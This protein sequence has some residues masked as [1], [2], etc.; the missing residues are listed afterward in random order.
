LL[1]PD[2]NPEAEDR[3]RRLYGVNPPLPPPVEDVVFRDLSLTARGIVEPS[4]V[5][6]VATDGIDASLPEVTTLTGPSSVPDRWVFAATTCR[7]RAL[8]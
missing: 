6:K 5:L 1:A 8:F 2:P 4:V 7:A 3:T